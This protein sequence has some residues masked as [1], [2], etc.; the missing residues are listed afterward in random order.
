MNVPTR[1]LFVRDRLDWDAS[2]VALEPD[3]DGNLTLARLPGLPGGAPVSLPGPYDLGASGIATGPCGALFMA[4]TAANRVIFLDTL[5][6]A[7]AE[8]GEVSQPRGLA[9]CGDWLWI[10]ETGNARL[11]R[12]AFPALELD[13]EITAGLSQPTGVACDHAGHLYVLDRGTACVR[14][15]LP[16]DDADSAYNARLAASGHI[17]APL[18]LA[19]DTEDRLLVADGTANAVRVFDRDGNAA[20]DVAS[21]PAGWQPGAMAA[22]A[23]CL[24]VADRGSGCIHVLGQD[25]AYWGALPGFRAPVTALAFDAV[26][27]DLLVK[28]GLDDAYLRLAATACYAAQGSITAGPFDAGEGLDWYRAACEA[29]TPLGTNLVFQVTQFDAPAPPPGPDEWVMTPAL[30]TL[31]ATVL[32]T[33]PAPTSRRYLWFRATLGTRDTQATPLLRNLRAETPGEDYRA[34]LPAIYSRAD[35]PGEFLAHFLALARSELGAVGERIDAIPQALSPRFAPAS[36]L[37]WLAAWLGLDLPLI[38]TDDERRTLI[39]R[40][41]TLYRRRGTPAGICDFVEIYTG[42]RPSII[43][44]FTER[45]LWVLDVSSRLDFDTGLPASDP[46]GMVVPD[47]LNPLNA[48]AGC[49]STTVGSAVVGESGPL[50]IEDLGEPLFSP[51]AHRFTVFLPAYRATQ[52]SLVAEVCGG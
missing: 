29:E 18:F 30:D 5:C 31:L 47:P 46:I 9:V 43:E 44:D 19:L 32:P 38:A 14:R 51:A 37:D 13:F 7:R 2:L 21:P 48:A 27:G 4:D 20:P 6:N 49:C 39:E 15:Y 36:E 25:A 10:A 3:A 22:G 23:G 41:A 16:P 28:T 34:Y 33:G 35:E 1:Y 50:P 8:L 40:A 11:R 12:L 42:V 45:G 24:F 26:T 52:N 17:V